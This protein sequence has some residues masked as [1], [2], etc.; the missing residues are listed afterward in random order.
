M[1][2]YAPRSKS[3]LKMGAAD[4]QPTDQRICEL[5]DVVNSFASEP[6]EEPESEVSPPSTAA[7]MELAIVTRAAK[8]AADYFY[9]HLQWSHGEYSGSGMRS[10]IEFALQGKHSQVPFDWITAAENDLSPTMTAQALWHEATIALGRRRHAPKSRRALAEELQELVLP[11]LVA[12]GCRVTGSKQ[13]SDKRLIS[14]PIQ[15]TPTGIVVGGG[16]V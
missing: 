1:N 7:A 3:Q 6:V 11:D 5:R 12:R 16:I 9:D 14:L 15:S 2:V 4:E 8:Y 10:E 13:K